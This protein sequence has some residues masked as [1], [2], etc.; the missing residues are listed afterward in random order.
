MLLFKQ[1]KLWTDELL[2]LLASKAG[3]IRHKEIPG[4]MMQAVNEEKLLRL[5]LKTTEHAHEMGWPANACRDAGLVSSA[6][7]RR[8]GGYSLAQLQAVD[9][10]LPSAQVNGN[11]LL[12][13]FIE[14]QCL[15]PGPA[16]SSS[17]VG[18]S[19]ETCSLPT[20]FEF[21]K[22]TD[23]DFGMVVE[24]VIKP[25]GWHTHILCV[26][27]PDGDFIGYN[28]KNYGSPGQIY[29]DPIWFSSIGNGK[30]EFTGGSGRALIRRKL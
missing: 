10:P 4:W 13:L 17:A 19:G 26:L 24:H 16:N 7:E 29:R 21:V 30:Y 23:D 8:D 25:Y 22:T 14:F 2:G 1:W 18:C 6:K 5:V 20:G 27:K 3:S 9:Y 12:T 11:S 15:L 28:G